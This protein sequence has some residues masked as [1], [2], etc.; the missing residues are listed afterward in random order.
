MANKAKEKNNAALFLRLQEEAEFGIDCILK[1]RLGDGY[2]AQTWGTN[3]WTDGFIGTNDDSTRR[4]QVLFITGHLK[5]L[6]LP[7]LKPT[8]L[9]TLKTIMR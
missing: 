8:H 4:R 5:T 1:G 2:R 7:V 9:C 6:F 3:L